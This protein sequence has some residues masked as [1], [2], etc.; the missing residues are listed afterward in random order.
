MPQSETG[1]EK[2]RRTALLSGKLSVYCKARLNERACGGRFASRSF[3]AWRV[4]VGRRWILTLI[5]CAE[6]QDELVLVP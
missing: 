5:Q 1:E 2:S 4:T 3:T 6:R